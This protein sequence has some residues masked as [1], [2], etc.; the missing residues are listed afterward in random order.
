M[1]AEL[2]AYCVDTAFIF[3]PLF[4]SDGECESEQYPKYLWKPLD[5]FE[6]CDEEKPLS[7]LKI[8]K[9]FTLKKKKLGE[10]RA[11][12]IEERRCLSVQIYRQIKSS[13]FIVSAL[14]LKQV[15]KLFCKENR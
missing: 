3:S 14:V 5:Q 11:L 12:L 9:G 10:R 2:S 4:N 7:M 8:Q 1:I 15:L 13:E 6:S